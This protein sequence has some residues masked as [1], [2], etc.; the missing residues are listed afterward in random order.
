MEE[1]TEAVD[2]KPQPPEKGL[3]ATKPFKKEKRTRP[4]RLV[5]S[6]VHHLQTNARLQNLISDRKKSSV[7]SESLVGSLSTQARP[8]VLAGYGTCGYPD[9]TVTIFV[10][11]V[12]ESGLLEAKKLPCFLLFHSNS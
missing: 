4:S 5:E 12:R 1:L 3:N 2:T 9:A 8:F 10:L 11:R 6:D 7:A